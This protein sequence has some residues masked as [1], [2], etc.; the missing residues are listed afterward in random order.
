MKRL[1]CL[2]LC[3]VLVIAA[4][5]AAARGDNNPV[6]DAAQAVVCI[7]AGIGYKNGKPYALN[8]KTYGTGTGFGVGLAGEDAQIF[9]TN[10]HV[11]SDR[12]NGKVTVYDTVYIF[13]DGADIRDE[14]TVVPCQ[15]LYA[16]EK[17][18]LAI[19]KANAPIPGVTTLP[20]CPAEEI[21][22]G[23]LVY[24]LGYPGISDKAADEN[25]YSTRDL[26]VTDGV[27]SRHLLSDGTKCMAHTASVNHGNSGGPLI[28]GKGQ[29][30]G[31][32]TFIN[33][34]KETADK[35][36]YAIYA[37]YIMDAMDN[38]GLPYRLG[39]EEPANTG[40][41]RRIAIAAV[42]AVAAL[43]IAAALV[44][45]LRR[46][47]EPKQSVIT[48][49]ALYG[50]LAGRSWQLQ[51]ELSIGRDP[52]AQ[53]V[54]PGDTKGVSRRHCVIRRQ[55]DSAVVVDM[56]STYGTFLN[57]RK[58]PPGQPMPLYP[59]AVISLASDQVQFMVTFDTNS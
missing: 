45:L 43:A 25:H 44:M 39:D 16:D 58:L 36:N 15:V 7:V 32:N 8:G 21:P 20:L 51:N 40:L 41:W 27:V 19:I 13:V 18:D 34:E 28:N 42:L 37:E 10:C 29:A 17:V 23:E 50:P 38:E 5:P 30:I 22:A 2:L 56:N 33:V 57:G 49:R 11:V 54:L 24:A 31:I 9:A 59:N 26:T 4:M 53:I 52:T 1:F 48:V 47:K 14:K 55:G 46:R 12:V 35:R 3:A 6:P